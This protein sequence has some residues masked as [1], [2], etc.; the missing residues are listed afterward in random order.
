TTQWAIMRECDKS[1]TKKWHD[2]PLLESAP[3]KAHSANRIVSHIGLEWLWLPELMGWCESGHRPAIVAES[4]MRPKGREERFFRTPAD[5]VHH[6]RA[7]FVGI[8]RTRSRKGW[9][10]DDNADVRL[11]RVQNPGE[12][13]AHRKWLGKHITGHRTGSHPHLRTRA[14]EVRLKSEDAT[15]IDVGVWP[16]LSPG[17]AGRVGIEVLHH[18][19]MH[20]L[21]QVETQS[22]AG[23]ADHNIGADS[24]ASR[25]ITTRIRNGS[26][27]GIVAGGDAHLD[28]CSSSQTFARRGICPP[29]SL[30]CY[31]GRQRT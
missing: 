28:P 1:G 3:L 31:R 9:D 29:Q 18:V 24:R 12:N 2:L 5:V 15:M 27:P 6:V 14:L 4:V 30:N 8:R 20:K 22:V 13:I 10:A 11:P 16:A 17:F 19:F 23:C 7:R 25:H 21:L 26:P